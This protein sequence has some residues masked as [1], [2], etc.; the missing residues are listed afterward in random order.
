MARTGTK[1]QQDSTNRRGY[2]QDEIAKANRRWDVFNLAGNLVVDRYRLERAN[3]TDDVYKDRYNILYSSIETIRPS[4]YA[5]T[6]K[7]QATKRHKDRNNQKVVYA[8]MLLE[9]TAQYALEEVDFDEV[10]TNAVEDYLLPGMGVAWV[11]YSPVISTRRGENDNET[12]ETLDFEGI[13]VD[14]VH[15]RDFRTGVG[16]TWK[17][18]PWIA[19]RVFFNREQA[20]KRWG[21]EKAAKLQYSYKPSEDEGSARGID[22]EGGGF[23]G[24]QAVIWEIWNK[25]NR[26]VVWYSEDY[27]GDV[28]EEVEDPLHLKDFFPCPRPLRAIHNTRTFIPK[29]FYTQYKAQ[30]EQLDLLTERIRYL[31]EAVRVLGVYDGSQEQ[32]QQ[33]L[34]GKGNKLVAVQNWAAF[35]GSGGIN[36]AIQWVPIKD[37][38]TVLTE[39]LRQREV[40]KAEIYEI[41]GF[42]DIMR[43]VSKASETLG[44]QQ[45]KSEWASG[46]LR[47]MQKEVQRFCRD[48]IRLITE[49]VSEQF[50]DESF[51]TY[52]GFEPPEVTPEEQAAAA[53]Y[54]EQMVQYQQQQASML[55]LPGQPQ[56][57]PPQKPPPT[58]RQQA[59][60]MFLDVLELVR[61]E[62]QRC[63]LIGIETDSTIMP[64]EAAERKDRTDFLGAAGSF[65]QQAG[66][67]AL[68]YPDMRGLLGALLM[69]TVRTFPASRPIEQEFEEF[70]KKLQ[71]Q[72]A[73]PPPGQGGDNP[74]SAEATA[75]GAVQ[76]EQIKAQVQQQQAAAEDATKRYEIDQKTRLE[77]QKLQQDHDY[78]MA[79]LALEERKV[80]VEEAN[81]D[82]EQRDV[83]HE[84]RMDEVRESREERALDIEAEHGDRQID[85]AERAASESGPEKGA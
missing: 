7:V 66:P 73:T 78:R 11:R 27:P 22:R 17:E 20:K 6:P 80:R 43:G 61:S 65:L 46:R 53:Q 49:I 48:I 60:K 1:D 4:L 82:I 19:R 67:M 12:Y 30:A 64:D 16:R 77:Q 63:A 51:A 52:A 14:Y 15:Y 85:A 62:K 28:L 44:A 42:G 18:L 5:K 45:I 13:D 54:A 59:I 3:S 47:D 33:L 71:A 21:A 34:N 40:V 81:L 38:A 74:Q 36:G 70:T 56:A 37:V 35:A 23:G 72:P 25:T 9:T 76:Q 58:E 2:W 83:Q 31:T 68:Q 8:T 50:S 29:A 55:T 84:Q 69:F 79:Q 32:L 41:S 24:S 26:K 39:L 10:I 75:K 57:P